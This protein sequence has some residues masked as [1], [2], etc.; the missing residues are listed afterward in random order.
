MNLINMVS[1]LY[2]NIA[3]TNSCEAHV[4]LVPFNFGNSVRIRAYQHILYLLNTSQQERESPISNVN[5]MQQITVRTH[6]F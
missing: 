6:F 4:R 2:N 3:F 1:L 5:F